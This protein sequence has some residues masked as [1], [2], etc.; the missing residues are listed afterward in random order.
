MARDI[1][2]SCG[3]AYNGRK[4][5]SCLYEHFSEEIAHGNHTHTGEP[6]VIPG[7]VRRPIRRKDPFGCEKKTRRKRPLTGFVILLALINIL[8]PMLRDWGL[9]LETR[10]NSYIAMEPEPVMAPEEKVILHQEQGVT[11]FANSEDFEDFR[12]GLCV[13]VEYTGALAS[14]TV[15]AGDIKV[16][17]CDMPFSALV[18]KARRGGEI[19]KGWLELAE[20]D[21]EANSLEELQTLSMTLTALGSNGRALFTTDEITVI[22]EGAA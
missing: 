20:R 21:L 11:I 8:L 18:C 12:D 13:Y 6:L 15:S 16:N 2:P 7:P 22:A 9:D 4:C 19:G 1:C 17:G 14:V 5:R 10:E 3:A